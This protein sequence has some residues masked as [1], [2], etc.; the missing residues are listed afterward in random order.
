MIQFSDAYKQQM[1]DE[2][3]LQRKHKRQ[4]ERIAILKK[5]LQ[6]LKQ[7]NGQGVIDNYLQVNRLVQ[8][9]PQ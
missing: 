7:L 8:M 3:A 2:R 1:R 5:E 4:E 9:F 6:D